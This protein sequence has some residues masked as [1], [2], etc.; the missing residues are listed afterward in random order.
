MG[1]FRGTVA[2]FFQTKI[3]AKDG[4]HSYSDRWALGI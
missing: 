3:G 2:Y 1:L 4:L